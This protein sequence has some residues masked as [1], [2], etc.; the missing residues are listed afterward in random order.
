MK[1]ALVYDRVTKWGGAE[2]VLLALHSIWPDAPL[3]TAVFDESK[4]SWAKVFRV[5]PSFL[6]C[7]PFANRMH[8]FLPVLTPIAFESF[9]F[10]AYDVVISVTSAEA[11][12][13]VTKPSCVHICYCLTPTRYLWSGHSDYQKYPGL[14]WASPI[15]KLGLLLFGPILRRWDLVFASRPDY[16]IAISQRVKE[17][18]ER[19]YHRP[20]SAVLYPPVSLSYVRRQKSKRSDY[21]LTVSRLVGYKR[22]DLIVDAFNELGVPLVIIGNGKDKQRLRRRARTNIHFIDRYLTDSELL[23]YYE[24]CRAFVHAADEDFGLAAAEAQSAG[25]PVIA[26]RHS[27]VSEFVL[28][29]KSGVLFDEQTEV[30]L[31]QAV[32]QFCSLTVSESVC[33]KQGMMA[34]EMVFAVQMKKL[35]EQCVK[36]AKR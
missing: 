10:D 31:I 20:V 4:A 6:Q 21:F 35:V 3:Y 15:A 13:I 25:A 12:S 26:Y 24:G 14:G 28:D 9:S 2:R 7:I 30:S 11:K 34:S 23:E 8:E 27:G 19:Y 22:V 16:F 32:E 1:V 18:I 29:G 33:R 36:E 5:I 17:R